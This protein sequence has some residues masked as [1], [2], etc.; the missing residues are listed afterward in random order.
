MRLLASLVFCLAMVGCSTLA[1]SPQTKAYDLNTK[2]TAAD[3]AVL[4][5]VTLPN[6]ATNGNMQPCS[7]TTYVKRLAQASAAVGTAMDAYI[8][9][10]RDPAYTQGGL[11]AANAAVNNALIALTAILAEIGIQP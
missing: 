7:K 6:C 1:T 8:A 4:R 5:Y 11:Q 9:T 3:A 2:V 10:V